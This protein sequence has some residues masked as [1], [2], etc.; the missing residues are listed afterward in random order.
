MAEQQPAEEPK[1]D[2]PPSGDAVAAGAAT[3]TP[4]AESPAGDAAPLLTWG[5][6][7][8]G[9]LTSSVNEAGLG[10]AL[11][12]LLHRCGE[13]VIRKVVDEPAPETRRASVPTA[14]RPIPPAGRPIPP[15]GGPEPAPQPG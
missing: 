5:L 8:T 3:E 10:A 12:R 6:V 1:T 11:T 9:K 15:A 2:T 13:P 14:G 4:P 7:V